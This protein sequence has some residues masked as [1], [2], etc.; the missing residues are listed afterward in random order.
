MPKQI[1]HKINSTIAASL[2]AATMLTVPVLAK[3]SPMQTSSTMQGQNSFAKIVARTR[4]AVVSIMVKKSKASQS[5]GRSTHRP[6]MTEKFPM[7]EFFKRFGGGDDFMKRFNTPKNKNARIQGSGFFVSADG[8]IVTND[9]VVKDAD[10]ITVRMNNGKTL[11]AK[12]IGSDPKTD[13]AVIKVKGKDFPHVAFGNSEKVR[14]GDWVVAVGNPYG[15]AGTTTAGIVSARGREIGFGPYDFIQIDASINSGNS[16]GPT[17][18]SKGEVIGI[19]TSIYSPSGGN[20]GIGFAIPSNLANKVVASLISDGVVK[21]AWLGVAIQSVTEDLAASMGQ[22]STTGALIA[23]ISA[24]SPAKKAVLQPG[25]I[26]T[27]LDG[28]PVGSARDLSRLVADQK[29]DTS[30]SLK[31]RRNG[32]SLTM[33]VMLSAQPGQKTVQMKASKKSQAK[34]GI[35][36]RNS[37]RGVVV[38]GVEPGSPAEEKGLATG[39]VIASVDNREV[40]SAKEVQQAVRV[41]KN[42]GKSLVLMLV[43]NR[44][45]SRYVAL[46]MRRG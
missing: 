24:D 6:D 31:I 8:Y 3:P 4:P 15:L 38:A 20:V 19:N 9:H 7:K 39:D 35:M 33:K 43:K 46:K 10:K 5:G 22:K 30:V 42:N 2:L 23:S 18:N 13:L 27:H 11:E 25:D 32:K 34:L 17:F 45:G 26:V 44:D 37:D 28:K 1:T 12:L 14:V 41:A 40:K 36:L 21:R 16:G 29:P